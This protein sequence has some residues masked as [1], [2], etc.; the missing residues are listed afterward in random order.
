MAEKLIQIEWSYGFEYLSID[1]DKLPDDKT[2]I[3]TNERWTD[4]GKEIEYNAVFLRI[5]TGSLKSIKFALIYEHQKNTDLPKGDI[6]WGRTDFTIFE[7]RVSASF[8][9]SYASDEKRVDQHP[10]C[11]VLQQG[12]D[13]GHIQRGLVNVILRARQQTLR[14]QLIK[15]H[16][17]TCVVSGE[18]PLEVL[19]AAHIVAVADGGNHTHKNAFLLRADLHRLFDAGMLMIASNGKIQVAP[20]ASKGIYAEF[21]IDKKLTKRVL[22]LVREA[23]EER[24]KI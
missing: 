1:P 16:G 8:K 24:E 4:S 17:P 20:E 19:D 15:F 13:K 7:N 18:Q 9:A 3:F 21:N 11:R 6:C 10:R 23:L 2:I 14:R 22:D 12:F 5:D